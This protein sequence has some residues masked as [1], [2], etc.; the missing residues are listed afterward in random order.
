MCSTR[1]Q[2]LKFT[3][4]VTHLHGLICECE[5]PVVH[6]LQILLDQTSKELTPN[7]QKQ[8]QKCLGTTQEDVATAADGLDFGDDL[9]Q[10]F[11]EDIEEKDGR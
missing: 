8:L 6:S 4:A 1:Q 5:E 10:L 3:N 2:N 7:Q 11:A 9:E